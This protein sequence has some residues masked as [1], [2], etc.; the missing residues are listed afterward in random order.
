MK[1][2]LGVHKLNCVLYK[3][4]T[5][6]IPSS[7]CYACTSYKEE[8]VSHLL[9]RCGYFQQKIKMLWKDV[10]EMFPS[11]ILLGTINSMNYNN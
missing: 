3:D 9:F 6:S 2:M 8:S 5:S 10:V 7:L 11:Q 4:K 1:L